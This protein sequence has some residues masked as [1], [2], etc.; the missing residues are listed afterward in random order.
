MNWEIAIP[1]LVGALAALVTRTGERLIAQYFDRSAKR[2]ATYDADLAALE[3]VIFE[4]RDLATGYWSSEP[5][6]ERD[7]V[8]EAAIVGRLSFVAEI[9]DEL[10]RQKLILLHDMQVA[11]NKFDVS[12]TL[13]NF[14]S[15]SRQADAGRC[16][17]IEVSA[18]RLVHRAK[19]YRRKL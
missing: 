19:A 9:S 16:R 2:D 11:I 14:G 3:R 6:P 10:F 8:T 7:K 18:Y 5:M 17:D 15:Q 13:G 4:I 12:C 1:A